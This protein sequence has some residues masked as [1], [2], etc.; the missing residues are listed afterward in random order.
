M[1]LRIDE[2]PRHPNVPRPSRE[3]IQRYCA[4]YAH[5][6]YAGTE[7]GAESALDD[8]MVY[9]KA[10]AVGCAHPGMCEPG[11]VSRHCACTCP[12]CRRGGAG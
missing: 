3:H 4:R 8:L 6:R 9:V 5:E 2:R 12:M 11:K 1:P 10:F 7:A